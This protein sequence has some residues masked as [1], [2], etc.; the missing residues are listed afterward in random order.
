MLYRL[1]NKS[2]LRLACCAALTFFIICLILNLH[3]YWSFYASFDQGLFNQL[4]WNSIHGNLFESS[5]SSSLSSNVVHAQQAPEVFYRH[6]GQHFN[7]IFLLWMPIYAVFPYNE[8]LIILQVLFVT[9]AGLVLYALAR[10]YLQPMLAAMI[11]ISFYCTATVNAPTLAN[12][13]DI[14]V[15]PLLLF[16]VLFAMEKQK[17][18]LFFLSAILLLAVRQDVGISL[19]G[20]GLYMLCS[21]RFPRMGIL[22]CL[23]SFG[24]ILLVT[25][26][27]MP[28]FSADVGRRMIMER[29]GQFATSG[30]AST[31]SLIWNI[32]TNPIRLL[33]ELFRSFPSKMGYIAVHSLALGLVPI[34][35]STTWTSASFPL[36][37]LFL[38]RARN[39]LTI[40]IRYAMPV[41]PGIFYGAIIWWSTRQYLYK[42][43]KIRR[44]WRICIILSL[45]VSIFSNQN[46][47]FYFLIPDSINPLVYT[48]IPEQWNHIHQFQPLL[49][50]IPATA[51]VSTTTE[52][53]PQLSNRREIVRLP[54]IELIN[55]ARQTVKVEYIIAD[56]W[57]R[58]KY[59]VALKGKRQALQ[60]FFKLIDDLTNNQQYGIIGFADGVILLQLSTPSNPQAIKDWLSF[61]G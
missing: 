34:L 15:A 21:R 52:L 26:F 49:K 37:Y 41:V 24:Y 53:I 30:E 39:A 54:E 10:H 3:R 9:L 35:S 47:V 5:L 18:W 59:Q 7:P 20:I 38:Q 46:S 40:S 19:F 61:R 23:L 51:S 11:T 44:F 13:H 29:F 36:L 6:L 43:P 56:V 31:L 16:A 28:Q 25:Q 50:Q 57:R 60:D 8:T 12:F 45:L 48:S 55:D 27:I 33:E 22:V 1:Q 14:S 17:W 2:G 32:L 4:F 58:H 42:Q